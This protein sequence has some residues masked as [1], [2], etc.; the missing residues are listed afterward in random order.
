[1]NSLQQ[2]FGVN[3]LQELENKDWS[4]YFKKQHIAGTERSEEE[5]NNGIQRAYD[6]I[7]GS[8]KEVSTVKQEHKDR[9]ATKRAEQKAKLKSER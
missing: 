7:H 1:M 2:Q 4:H 9:L 8:I 5:I 6:L 3:S